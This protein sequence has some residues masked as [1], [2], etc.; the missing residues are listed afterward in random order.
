M[1]AWN[2]KSIRVNAD[3]SQK[4]VYLKK[5][6]YVCDISDNGKKLTQPK[7]Y[8]FSTNNTDTC[9]GN[10]TEGQINLGQE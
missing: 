3:G 10:I 4:V 7:I 1:C 9:K 5:I 8:F 6:S 2:K